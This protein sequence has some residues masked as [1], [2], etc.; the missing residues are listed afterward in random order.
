MTV[1]TSVEH[2]GDDTAPD[3]PLGRTERV[4]PSARCHACGHTE[5]KA[6][7]SRC[8]RP[9]CQQHD[10]P[11]GP[12]ER[13]ALLGLFRVDP[14]GDD[15]I[16][17]PAASSAKDG[18]PA[19]DAVAAKKQEPTSGEP[20]GPAGDRDTGKD[21]V[22]G[23]T[24]RTH[25]EPKGADDATSRPDISSRPKRRTDRPVG[26][27]RKHYCAGCVPHARPLDAEMIAAATTTGLG[28]AV[29]PVQ[30]V[31]GGVLV[32]AGAVRLAIR[33]VV[34]LRR[35]ATQAADHGADLALNPNV[36]KLKARERIRGSA[37]FTADRRYESAVKD[38][39][40][41]VKLDGHWSRAHRSVLDMH[42]RRTKTVP[43]RVA[44]GH[45]V[46][47]GPGRTRFRPML[48]ASAN[49]GPALVLK[50]IVADQS[51]LCGPAGHGDSRWQPEF[52][53]DISP[54]EDGWKLPLWVVPNI[55]PELD[56][57]V[58]ELYVQWSTR[59]PEGTDKGVP[60]RSIA[61]LEIDVPAHWGEV[62]YVTS[63]DGDVTIGPPVPDE[64][65]GVGL[66]KVTWRKV[67]FDAAGDRG[68][69]RL[70]IRFSDRI[71][72]DHVLRGRI[73]ALFAG[74]VSGLTRVDLY[75]TDGAPA[76]LDGSRKL[77]TVVDVGLS[78]SLK[79][80]RYQEHRAVPDRAQAEDVR[81]QETETFPGVVPDH[82][83]VAL[84]TNNLSDEGY[85]II[86]V[87]ENPAQS[88]LRPGSLNRLW[89]LA[90]R[91][92]EGVYPI[93]FHLVLSGE[94]I[95]KGP[96]ATG[97]TTVALTVHGSY[98]NPVME[99]RVVEEWTRLWKRIRSSVSAASGGT[100]GG[101]RFSEQPLDASSRELARLRNLMV[102]VVAQISD[103][104]DDKRIEPELAREL[105][106]SL[107][108]E[109]GL[110]ER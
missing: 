63:L 38:V 26:A 65:G 106:A 90:G 8:G 75:R 39:V 12:P 92:Y 2:T 43:T 34:G 44:A 49:G 22:G 78:L 109:F 81:R 31:V 53:Y 17:T 80:L 32:V 28:A 45:L 16:D 95:H 27:A 30:P 10:C 54:P 66:R 7:C 76:H 103:A 73:E 23:S 71:D 62:E 84:L 72:L 51:S 6:L 50:P 87:L 74:A 40:G 46:L 57:H 91:Y 4:R 94:E 100:G 77:V 107:T 61:T 68:S 47:H 98:A 24:G 67:P 29:L 11:A 85:Y 36:R 89:D 105:D 79:G 69:A 25:D 97:E 5:I 83:T 88:S 41:S 86:R 21:Q 9:L 35:R 19:R 58:L 96:K 55:A 52:K 15:E 59:A 18:H 56:R 99:R 82:H 60:L 20:A 104:V 64:A 14:D 3:S 101:P 1:G 37:G 110:G 93:D 33:T 102:T 108:D 48:D 13:R 70:A 42:R